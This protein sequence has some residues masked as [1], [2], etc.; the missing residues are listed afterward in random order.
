VVG[1]AERGLVGIVDKIE[2]IEGRLFI[3]R[4]ELCSHPSWRR[5]PR[6]SAYECVPASMCWSSI[7]SCALVDP[8]K[9][10]HSPVVTIPS[11]SAPVVAIVLAALLSAVFASTGHADDKQRAWRKCGSIAFTPNSDDGVANIRARRV[12]CRTARHVARASEPTSV[13][14]GPSTY[15]APGFT[16]RGR[17][18]DDGLPTVRWTCTRKKARV[19]FLMS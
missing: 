10:S 19:K 4:F 9:R 18:Q 6:N 5:P 3:G 12:P 13:I 2:M 17:P 16:C 7:L 11:R 1:D 14:D 8:P 15:R